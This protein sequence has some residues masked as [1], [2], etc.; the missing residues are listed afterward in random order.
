[1]RK[2]NLS[3][4]LLDPAEAVALANL[5]KALNE[6]CVPFIAHNEGS[7]AYLEITTGY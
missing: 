6:A 7:T 3:F 5:V 1:M 2:Q 4:H